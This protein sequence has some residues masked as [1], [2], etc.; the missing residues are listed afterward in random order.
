MYYNVNKQASSG[1]HHI[2]L[3]NRTHWF[4]PICISSPGNLCNLLCWRFSGF[5]S[6]ILDFRVNF[7]G[8]CD[9]GVVLRFEVSLF[10][11]ETKT[12]TKRMMFSHRDNSGQDTNRQISSHNA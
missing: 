3:T 10:G 7:F 2:V 4:V 1:P 8:V 9:K 12:G 6:Q 11:G 5:S